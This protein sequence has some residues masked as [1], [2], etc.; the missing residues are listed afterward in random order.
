[1][2]SRKTIVTR[3]RLTRRPCHK[4]VVRESLVKR[5]RNLELSSEVYISWWV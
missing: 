3:K 4:K 2:V 1:M 5:E